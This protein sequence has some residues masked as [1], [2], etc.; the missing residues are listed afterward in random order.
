MLRQRAVRVEKAME[1]RDLVRNAENL[2]RQET[3]EKKQKGPSKVE[4]VVVAAQEGEEDDGLTAD[5]RQM[6]AMENETL[7]NALDSK[8]EHVRSIESQVRVNAYE[9]DECAHSF[10]FNCLCTDG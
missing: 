5:E 2:L 9:I 6:L 1:Q 8:L 10:V 4:T 3:D 7:F